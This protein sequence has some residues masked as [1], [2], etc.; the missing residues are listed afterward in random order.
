[1]NDGFSDIQKYISIFDRLMRMYYDR[2]LS[3]FEIGWGQQ[4]YIEYLY[5]HPGATPQEMAQFIRVDSATLTKII[6]K[7]TEVEYIRV[8]SDARDRRVKHL[9]LTDKAV[10]A[11]EKVKRIHGDFYEILSAGISAEEMD[12]AVQTLRQ[13]AENVTQ[14]VWHKRER[15]HDK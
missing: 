9:F 8:K 1:M 14:K 6:R 11:A 3:G 5:D 12:A 7:L 15:H 2:E 10:P 4:F 13:M